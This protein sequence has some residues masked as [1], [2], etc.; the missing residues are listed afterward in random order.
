MFGEASQYLDNIFKKL[1]AYPIAVS[2]ALRISS[3]LHLLLTEETKEEKEM[4]GPATVGPS[5]PFLRSVLPRRAV[6]LP[7]P[8]QLPFSPCPLCRRRFT[9]PGAVAKNP[10]L[11]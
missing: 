4:R 5:F 6:F 1:E 9:I 7:L 2:A 10:S 8:G 11:S 3:S